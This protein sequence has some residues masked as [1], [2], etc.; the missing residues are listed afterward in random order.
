MEEL[1][2]KGTYNAGKRPSEH[3]IGLT[4]FLKNNLGAIP[5]NV[6]IPPCEDD[7]T[8]LNLLGFANTAASDPYQV[9]CREHGVVPHPARMQPKL[10][11]FFIEFLTDE[12]DIVLDP[13]AGSNTTGAVAERL[14][15]NWRAIELDPAYVEA[16]R[17]RFSTMERQPG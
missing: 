6:L 17:S 1:L 8:P 13:F 11:E 5:P 15:R 14:K 10:A 12:G 3:N 9:Y 2:R 16:S 4:S 7:V